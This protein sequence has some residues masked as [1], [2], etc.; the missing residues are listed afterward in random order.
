M[1]KKSAVAENITNDSG[2]DNVLSISD[3]F[4]IMDDV[5]PTPKREEAAPKAVAEEAP[6]AETEKEPAAF[7]R[8]EPVK[9]AEPTAPRRNSYMEFFSRRNS[10]A[11]AKKEPTED[12]PTVQRDAQAVEP[13]KTEPAPITEPVESAPSS[14]I[15]DFDFDILG[16]ESSTAGRVSS[17][18]LNAVEAH[19]KAK[20][21]A[22]AEKAAK[23][24]EKANEDSE[25]TYSASPTPVS[26]NEPA[27][28]AAISDELAEAL[29]NAEEDLSEQFREK[30]TENSYNE[31]ADEPSADEPNADDDG[32]FLFSND[33][34]YDLSDINADMLL[35]P[36]KSEAPDH[37]RLD[38]KKLQAEVEESIEMNKK[39][40]DK[41]R[42]RNMRESERRADEEK[43][44]RGIQQPEDPDIFFKRPGKDYYSESMPEIRFNRHK[45]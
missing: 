10:P 30:Y 34:D 26:Q 7:R 31:P 44:K 23:A 12:T 29:K 3:E 27:P 37:K 36:E 1:N 18:A 9:P 24:A 39:L 45:H 14:S 21:A 35:A 16:N 2:N 41:E 17:R 42:A 43:P 5:F 8:P 40:R 6:A 4:D 32:E 38:F 28:K 11:E 20:A 15:D 25:D 19:A 13:V 22:E 33:A